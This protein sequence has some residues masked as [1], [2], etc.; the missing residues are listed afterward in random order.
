MK[1]AKK[2]FTL[3]EL[4]VTTAIVGILASIAVL[5]Y[6]EVKQLAINASITS[7]VK[8]YERIISAYDMYYRSGEDY[9][10]TLGVDPSTLLPDGRCPGTS[11]DSCLGARDG[12]TTC[13]WIGRTMGVNP[14]LTANLEKVA[15]IPPFPRNAKYGG[16]NMICNSHSYSVRLEWFLLGRNRDCN[17]AKGVQISNYG[18]AT[19]RNSDPNFWGSGD[20][21]CSI[22]LA[23]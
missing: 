11:G 18:N 16:A 15:K 12:E 9:K 1:S 4:L 20:T 2:A 19:A 6:E 8:E 23:S 5:N 3:V 7:T 17:F 13:L 10:A 21:F 22:D 14:T